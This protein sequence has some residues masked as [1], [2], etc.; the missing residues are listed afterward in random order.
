[1]KE[2]IK[3]LFSSL[4]DNTKG[5]SSRKLSAFAVIICIVISHVFWLRNCYQL[6]D[7]SDFSMILTINYGFVGALLGLTTYS[8]FKSNPNDK[9]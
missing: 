1:M 7:F 2:I 6:K 5:L 4:D 3:K 8:K 9:K